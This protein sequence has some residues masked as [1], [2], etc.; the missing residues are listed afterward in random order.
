MPKQIFNYQHNWFDYRFK[1][2][3]YQADNPHTY[4]LLK[5]ITTSWKQSGLKDFIKTGD[6]SQI[7][8]QRHGDLLSFMLHYEHIYDLFLIDHHGNIV[9]TVKHESDIGENVISG[10][11]QNTLFAMTVKASLKS[12][13]A[14]FS[15]LEFYS[16]SANKLAG[17]LTMPIMNENNEQ[18][19]VMTVHFKMDRVFSA[20]R[21][22]LL[23]DCR[24]NNLIWYV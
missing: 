5:T 7:S 24:I 13:Q 22:D 17:F 3:A 14:L 20:I 16:P 9:Y 1:D 21:G 23:G 18:T 4:K 15:H 12:G 11:I 2:V 19:G 10:V 6:W 8:A